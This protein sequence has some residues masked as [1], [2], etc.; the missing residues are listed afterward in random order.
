MELLKNLYSIHAK[1]GQ[2]QKITRFIIQYLNR[3]KDVS[4]EVDEVGNLYII[5][6]DSETYPCIVA[7]LDQV[8]STH[9]KDFKAV[10]TEDI[11]FGYSPNK[12]EYQGLGADDKN[13]IWIALKCLEKSPVM[14]CAFF[15]SEEVGC[16]GSSKCDMSF[17]SDVRFVVQ[18]D[19]KGGSDLI[20]SISG[21]D[22]ASKDF[23]ND[24]DYEDFGYKTTVGL[25]T[26]VLELSERGVGVSCINLSCGYYNPHT[27]EEFT[28]ISD[29]LNALN[30]V[31]HIVHKCT[32]VYYHKVE[33]DGSRWSHYGLNRGSYSYKNYYSAYNDCPIIPTFSDYGEVESYISALIA[34]NGDEF[35]PEELWPYVQADLEQY[36]T[37]DEF[38]EKA[39]NYWVYYNDYYDSDDLFDEYKMRN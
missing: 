31:L 1:S 15:V 38:T 20:N 39:Y 6:G 5:K 22:I 7:H 25:M 19:R 36:L 11:I 3:F 27:D 2:E 17:F 16:I 14:K 10:Q 35:Y 30:L 37:E 13:G 4:C 32:K 9:A 8:Q 28:C 12:R 21:M 26:D 24:I 33:Y 18:P 23:L 34:N 29:L